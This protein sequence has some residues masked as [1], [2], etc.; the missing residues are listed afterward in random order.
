MVKFVTSAIGAIWW[1][2]NLEPMQVLPS[3]DQIWTNA[4]VAIWWPNF[5]LMQ[6]APPGDQIW[7]ECKWCDLVTNFWTNARE[8]IWWPNL[9][10]V[11][12]VPLKSILNYSNWKVYWVRCA[13]GNVSIKLPKCSPFLETLSFLFCLK[14]ACVGLLANY[15][16]FLWILAWRGFALN[17][18][19]V[20]TF[21]F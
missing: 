17:S 2:S 9:Q 7:N 15:S 16:E 21:K 3:G 5:E 8:T 11:Q 12:V 6:V 18:G 1:W 19:P 14:H 10:P 13:S 20:Q 4:S